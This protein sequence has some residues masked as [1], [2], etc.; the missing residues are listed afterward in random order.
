MRN[1]PCDTDEQRAALLSLTQ[2][3][4]W[5]PQPLPLYDA[6]G[7]IVLPLDYASILPGSLASVRF[8]L[9]RQWDTPSDSY[10]Y[11]ANVEEIHII[12]KTRI[13][14]GS[15]SHVKLIECLRNMTPCT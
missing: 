10:R 11:R 14:I 2:E 9:T 4:T 13:D 7:N 15:N 3:G 6:E 8:T 12:D 5:I 1:C